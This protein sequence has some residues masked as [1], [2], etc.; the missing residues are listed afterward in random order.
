M[1]IDYKATAADF[2]EKFSGLKKRAIEKIRE[3]LLLQKGCKV[4]FRIEDED[5]ELDENIIY[6]LVAGEPDGEGY[7][8]PVLEVRIVGKEAVR[9]LTTGD[10]RYDEYSIEELSLDDIV[11]ILEGICTIVSENNENK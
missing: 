6:D 1:I 5:A 2:T 7:R 3:I 4:V 10:F 9:V 11:N 8:S